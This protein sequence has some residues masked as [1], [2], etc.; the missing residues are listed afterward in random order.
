M[1]TSH[2]KRDVHTFIAPDSGSYFL[3]LVRAY[4]NAA[5]RAGFIFPVLIKIRSFNNI[6]L[7][8][9]VRIQLLSGS[10]GGYGSIAPGF[11]HRPGYVKR[12]LHP[13]H[14]SATFTS[15]SISNK[16][17]VSHTKIN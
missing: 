16:Q 12:L 9:R 13:V 5:S 8:L 15:I 6:N 10:A 2:T 7:Q 17:D 4:Y 3:L 14:K 11:K 1:N